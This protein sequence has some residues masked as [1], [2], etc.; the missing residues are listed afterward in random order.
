ML[1]GSVYSSLGGFNYTIHD[2][3]LFFHEVH[4]KKGPV[5]GRPWV[6]FSHIETTLG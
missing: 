2:A 5:D 1:V 3:S 4:N 6:F